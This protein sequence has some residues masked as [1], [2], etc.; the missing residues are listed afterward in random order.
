M[1]NIQENYTQDQLD[2]ISDGPVASTFNTDIGDYIRLTL[3]NEN[4]NY[5]GR[6][7]YSNVDTVDANGNTVP[8]I[9]I[10]TGAT[11]NIFVKPNEILDINGVP[12][13]N[14]ILQFDF[15]KRFYKFR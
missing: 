13:G 9:G 3:L 8:E 7:F 14:Y 12:S 4:G 1:P 5:T 10:Y 11:D 2:I 6:Q 15:F